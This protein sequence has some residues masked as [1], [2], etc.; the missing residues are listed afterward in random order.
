[1][2]T[3]ALR[4]GQLEEVPGL[5][6]DS[7]APPGTYGADEEGGGHI[8][9]EVLRG[10]DSQRQRAIKLAYR[11]EVVWVN[12]DQETGLPYDMYIRSA[13]GAVLAYVEVKATGSTGRNMFEVSPSELRYHVIRIWSADTGSA[14]PRILRLQD[15]VAMWQAKQINV[16][17]VT[18]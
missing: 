13:S 4:T 12:R 14:L 8:P 17:I 3:S 2:L 1:M 6:S 15:P 16:C 10:H 18:S 11:A 7:L 9:L 5:S